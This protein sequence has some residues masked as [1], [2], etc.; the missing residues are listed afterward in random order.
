MNEGEKAGVDYFGRLRCIGEYK[1]G[2]KVKLAPA[3]G[4]LAFSDFSKNLVGVL[5]Y[6]V[7]VTLYVLFGCV[8]RGDSKANYV[9]V[10]D[11]GRHNMDSAVF[12]QTLQ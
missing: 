12:V 2:L 1:R 6:Y 10:F 8:E 11:L 5:L 7:P 3:L 9:F 4:L